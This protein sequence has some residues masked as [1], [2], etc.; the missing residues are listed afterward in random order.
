MSVCIHHVREAMTNLSAGRTR[1]LLRQVLP[2][3]DGR[4]FG[5][6]P[7]ALGGSD[8]FGAKIIGVDPAN[9]G[10]GK[11]SHQGGILLF[12]PSDSRPLA[13]VH[14][15]EV[16]AIRT[17]AAS[18]VATDALA[19]SEGSILAILGYG[20]QALA[21][22]EAI[23]IVRRIGE[24]RIWGRDP[25]QAQAFARRIAT[26]GCSAFAA[27]DPASCVRG[28]HIICTTTSAS[29][30]LLSS[31]DIDPGTHLNL[32]GSS[33]LG[34]R[35]IDDS[36]VSRARFFG[37][38]RAGVLA[39]GAEFVHAREAGLIDDE[40]FLGEIGEVLAGRV[41]GRRHADDVTIYK[42]L[43]HV[44]QDLASARAVYEAARSE[45]MSEVPF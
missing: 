5:V 27:T 45:G 18:A 2:L 32:V 8:L 36:L 22:V 29:D 12:D 26:P 24:I 11:Q 16:T 10:R 13:L 1:Q 14:A 34:P 33:V 35:E 38:Y 21:H 3:D 43:G 30:P 15:G 6:M 20:E 41:E 28:A 25:A 9:R 17:A 39:Q 4:A 31:R 19:L 40:H 23:R 44:V 7:G 37:D 42:S